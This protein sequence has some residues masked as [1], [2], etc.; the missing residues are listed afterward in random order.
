PYHCTFFTYYSP[1]RRLASFPTRRS[2]DL[3]NRPIRGIVRGSQE[4]RSALDDAAAPP[5][6]ASGPVIRMTFEPAH[7]SVERLGDDDPDE[8]VRQ[9]Q[10]RQR[11]GLVGALP[12]CR[13]EPVGAAVAQS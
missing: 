2:S 4:S 1:L 5:A 9:R 7:G 3:R 13:R 10:R 6:A 8:A 12:A 11:P